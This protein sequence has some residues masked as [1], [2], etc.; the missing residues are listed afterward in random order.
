MSE[1]SHSSRRREE[2]LSAAEK[3][4]DAHGFAAATIEAVAEQAGVAKGS[5]YNYFKSKRDLFHQVFAHVLAGA[6]AEVMP[7]LSDPSLSASAKVGRLLDHW[8]KRL[9]YY[10]RLG[11]LVLEFWAAAARE[12]QEHEL[13]ASLRAMYARWRGQIASVLEEGIASGEFHPQV[14]PQVWAAL[15]L[16]MLDGVEIQAILEMGITLDEP[17]L[18]AL[19]SSILMSLCVA[20]PGPAGAAQS[21]GVQ[22]E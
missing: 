18:A 6:E 20:G 4:F 22:D 16:A 15:L 11:R 14:D 19:K 21:G 12:R 9:D 17:F 2:I 13:T 3:V 5:V 8:A 1:A 7:F 10:S